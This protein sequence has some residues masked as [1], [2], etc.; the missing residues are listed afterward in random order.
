VPPVLDYSKA[1]AGSSA[2]NILVRTAAVALALLI[3]LAGVGS[4]IIAGGQ[5]YTLATWH[6]PTRAPVFRAA[7]EIP[8]FALGGAALLALSVRA[9]QGALRRRE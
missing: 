5:A 7:V 3:G 4:L 9:F 1:D 8:T 2:T 6:G